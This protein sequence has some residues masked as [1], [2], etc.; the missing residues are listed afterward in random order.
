MVETKC[1]ACKRTKSEIVDDL[2][3]LCEDKE[4]TRELI[5]N[6]V[7]FETVNSDDTSCIDISVCTVCSS[8]YYEILKGTL[9]QFVSRDELTDI[10]KII[11]WFLSDCFGGFGEC[12]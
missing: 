9:D 8:L 1:W 10:L 12:S 4:L 5:A 2:F 7:E 3:D 6:D 11:R